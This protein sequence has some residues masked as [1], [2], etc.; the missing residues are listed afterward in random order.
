MLINLLL[1][2]MITILAKKATENS[3]ATNPQN[4]R[5]HTSITSTSTLTSTSVTTLALGR[6]VLANTSSRVD[7][8]RLLQNETILDQLSDIQSYIILRMCG[9][10]RRVKW[11]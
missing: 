1:Y 9:R 4:L 3:H 6:Q 5:R 8:G 7:G 10:L 11:R 2:S